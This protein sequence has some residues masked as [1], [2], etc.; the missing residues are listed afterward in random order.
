MDL[1]R[2]IKIKKLNGVFDDLPDS[3]KFFISQFDKLYQ[4]KHTYHRIGTNE[5][6]EFYSYTHTTSGVKHLKYYSDNGGLIISRNFM[7]NL[8]HENNLK[9]ETQAKSIIMDIMNK[10]LNIRCTGVYSN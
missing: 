10:Y 2:L 5:I 7:I 9:D 4:R 6:V 8:I 3:Y 1:I